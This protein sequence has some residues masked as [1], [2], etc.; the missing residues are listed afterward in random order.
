MPSATS[1]STSIRRPPDAAS[2]MFAARRCFFV[3]F[4]GV[5]AVTSSSI[6]V[7]IVLALP[8]GT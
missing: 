3:G 4:C 6:V 2:A 8:V 1:L 5:S 7:L